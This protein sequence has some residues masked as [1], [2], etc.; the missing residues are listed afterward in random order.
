MISKATYFSFDSY[1]ISRDAKSID[2]NYSIGFDL[3]KPVHFTSSILLPL[4]ISEKKQSQPLDVILE[5]LHLMLGIS[6][7]KLY[8]PKE[9]R[10]PYVLDYQ[11][12]QF[13]NTVFTK[14]MGE[15]YYRNEIDF[16]GLVSFPYTKT[17]QKK[18]VSFQPEN[19]SLVGVAGG[20]DSIASV[21]LLKKT[22]KNITALIF[23][24]NHEYPLIRSVHKKMGIPGIYI[25]HMLDGKL[26]SLNETGIPYNGHIPISAIYAFLG[27]LI[28][29]IYDYS[30]FI[31]SNEKSANFGSIIHHGMEI[32]HQWSK[33][34]E[35]ERLFTSYTKAYITPDITYF[36]LLRPLTELKISSIF[37]Q[38]TK[39][40]P[41]FSSCNRNFLSKDSRALHGLTRS[42]GWCGRCPKCAFTFAMLGPWIPRQKLLTIFGHDLF[43]EKN[44]VFLYRKLLGVE[45]IKPFDCVGTFEEVAVALY[46]MYQKGEYAETPV[47]KM[48]VKDI[49]P[50][51][52]NAE[53][54]KKYVLEIA[55]KSNL[56]DNFKNVL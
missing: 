23:E 27:F 32:N 51:F 17:D 12:A 30:Y 43:S 20:K 36:S 28:S 49:L 22:G 14:G 3:A 7:W 47:M 21:E 45:D 8:C 11:Q 2:F 35:F 55:D 46:M 44:L 1:N 33:S 18:S 40:F 42:T 26:A 5:P 29:V 19:R 52:R 9:I 10:I 38:Y 39:Y 34:E 24:T 6:Y 16:R 48:F 56:P 31:V 25:K 4:P 13:W 41:Y 50:G 15:F 53:K 54:L 37:A